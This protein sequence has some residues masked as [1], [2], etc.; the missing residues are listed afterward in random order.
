MCTGA[1]FA[2]WEAFDRVVAFEDVRLHYSSSTSVRTLRACA[3]GPVDRVR[4][5]L[6]SDRRI[7][8]LYERLRVDGRIKALEPVE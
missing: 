1:T 3:S 5:L 7:W 2:A 4:S 6:R 8:L